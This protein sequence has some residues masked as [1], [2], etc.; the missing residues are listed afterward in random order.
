MPSS[1]TGLSLRVCEFSSLAISLSV[2]DNTIVRRHEHQR[3]DVVEWARGVDSAQ[4]TEVSFWQIATEHNR[5]GEGVC[6][7]GGNHVRR[8]HRALRVP[9]DSH[10]G[11]VCCDVRVEGGDRVRGPVRIVGWF[12][13]PSWRIGDPHAVTGWI[14]RLWE[15]KFV[16]PAQSGRDV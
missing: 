10:E 4:Q 6:W 13:F 7:T 8:E 11:P 9:H 15:V 14:R 12:T 1:G 5:P 3:G 16:G 2:G